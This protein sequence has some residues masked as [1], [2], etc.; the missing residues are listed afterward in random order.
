MYSPHS[1]TFFHDYIQMFIL[2]MFPVTVSSC[3]VLSI[4]LIPLFVSFCKI[5]QKLQQCWIGGIHKSEIVH[6]FQIKVANI[7]TN[8]LTLIGLCAQINVCESIILLVYNLWPLAMFL[9]VNYKLWKHIQ[10]IL[11]FFYWSVTVAYFMPFHRNCSIKDP[12]NFGPSSV[13]YLYSIWCYTGQ[14]CNGDYTVYITSDLYNKLLCVIQR[15][16]LLVSL[17]KNYQN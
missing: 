17:K 4:N 6:V 16:Q 7:W 5:V 8:K 10:I 14:H 2:Q 1:A 12:T 11:E 9:C 3:I 15:I 13:L